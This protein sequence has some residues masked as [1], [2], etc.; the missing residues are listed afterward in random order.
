MAFQELQSQSIESAT[1]MTERE[2]TDL[3]GS[4]EST[5]QIL[6]DFVLRRIRGRSKIT[7]F[8][9]I[10]RLVDLQF[11]SAMTLDFDWITLQECCLVSDRHARDYISGVSPNPR[12]A[13]GHML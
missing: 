5:N 7:Y 1:H 4:V 2:L 3:W 8:E 10:S 6:R 9:Y 13:A 12:T 11:V